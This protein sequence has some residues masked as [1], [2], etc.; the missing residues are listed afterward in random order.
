MAAQKASPLEALQRWLAQLQ[1]PDTSTNPIRRI[2]V[3]SETIRRSDNNKLLRGFMIADDLCMTR[4]RSFFRV[5]GDKATPVSIEEVAANY[6]LESMQAR[7]R[8]AM[9]A[10]KSA[11]RRKT[12]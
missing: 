11:Q 6:N 4:Q 2:E 3:L 12:R 10:W 9:D 5:D 1:N 7:Y 8:T